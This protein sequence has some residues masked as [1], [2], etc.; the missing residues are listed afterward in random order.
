MHTVNAQAELEAE[1]AQQMQT[2]FNIDPSLGRLSDA[3][4]R[5]A[6]SLLAARR[7]EALARRGKAGAAFVNYMHATLPAYLHQVCAAF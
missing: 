7:Q 2:H 5:R 6:L 1:L 3:G 4:Y